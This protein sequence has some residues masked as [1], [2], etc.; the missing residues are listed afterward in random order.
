MQASWIVTLARI[1]HKATRTTGVVVAKSLLRK[2]FRSK[3]L[4]TTTPVVRVA[5]CNIRA[6]VTIQLACIAHALFCWIFAVIPLVV[7]RSGVALIVR[8][9]DTRAQNNFPVPAM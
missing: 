9:N 5:L 3:D 8:G 6:S 2:S 1:L 4:A 7:E